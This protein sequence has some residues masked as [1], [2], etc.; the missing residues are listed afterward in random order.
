M[1]VCVYVCACACV[2]VYVCVCICVYVCVCVFMCVCMCVCVYICVCMC[3]GMC[4]CIYNVLYS[5]QSSG[6]DV[7]AVRKL[8]VALYQMCPQLLPELSTCTA[9]IDYTCE[10]RCLLPHF[11][12]SIIKLLTHCY[13]PYIENCDRVCNNQ[14]KIAKFLSLHY[15]NSYC[16]YWQ[17]KMFTTIM[18]NLMCFLL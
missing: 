16:L 14:L 13:M 17:K 5:R 3:V 8:L 15:H 10:V 1:C 4:M 6:G 9:P 18:R 12:W 2:C 11:I 7:L